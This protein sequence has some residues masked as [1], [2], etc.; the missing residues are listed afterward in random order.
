MGKAALLN[1]IVSEALGSYHLMAQ[2]VVA[3]EN[4]A[5]VEVVPVPS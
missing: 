3:Q 4:L 5:S 2:R 1:G